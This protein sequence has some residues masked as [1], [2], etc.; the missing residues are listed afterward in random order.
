MFIIWLVN[1]TKGYKMVLRQLVTDSS[2]INHY[3][4]SP[5]C[6]TYL[7]Y[8]LIWSMSHIVRKIVNVCRFILRIYCYCLCNA[9]I[10]IISIS[11]KITCPHTVLL[12]I[13]WQLFLLSAAWFS[14]RLAMHSSSN[15]VIYVQTIYA[16]N[17]FLCTVGYVTI[18][19]G[20]CRCLVVCVFCY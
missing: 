4:Y 15:S 18:I 13:L 7:Q 11:S 19:F 10:V 17:N 1:K 20:I 6:V 2:N 16:Q 12:S 14:V 9:Q 3:H 5:K 8:L